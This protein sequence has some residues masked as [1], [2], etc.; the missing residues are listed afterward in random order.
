MSKLAFT[1]LYRH[2]VFC[3]VH[4]TLYNVA[5]PL[6]SG[7]HLLFFTELTE[8]PQNKTVFIN[9]DA[10]FR[11]GANN[12]DTINWYIND[13]NYQQLEPHVRSEIETITQSV[14]EPAKIVIPGRRRFNNTQVWCEATDRR[15]EE[16]ETGAMSGTVTLYVQ[17]EGT[18]G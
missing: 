11:C 1:S 16:N 10:I 2:I 6:R 17:G 9:R 18:C 15:K 12:A 3:C 7:F 8:S 13:T 14:H 5:S 4:I